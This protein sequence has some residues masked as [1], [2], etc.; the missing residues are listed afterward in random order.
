MK[1]FIKFV[2]FKLFKEFRVGGFSSMGHKTQSP[3]ECHPN[4]DLDY[5]SYRLL[6]VTCSVGWHQSRHQHEKSHPGKSHAY[7]N[8]R[9]ILL[10]EDFKKEK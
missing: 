8:L 4:A 9:V 6:T 10:V 2:R 7:C 3:L 1:V 5:K